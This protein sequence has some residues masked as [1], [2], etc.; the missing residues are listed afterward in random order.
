[1]DRFTPFS[2]KNKKLVIGSDR[3]TID[4][5]SQKP[6]P[7]IEQP[8]PVEDDEPTRLEYIKSVIPP[9]KPK[10]RWPLIIG[11][12]IVV[13]VLAAG[14]Y[15]GFKHVHRK[16][17]TVAHD[18]TTRTHL[19]KPGSVT[20]ATSQYVSNGSDLNLTFTYPSNWSATPASG[21]NPNDQTITLTSPIQ[22]IVNSAG[23]AVSG[24]VVV[25]LRPASSTMS[26]LSSGE[27]T[28]ALA[29]TQFDYSKPTSSQ[30]QYPYLTYLD[31]N[32]GSNPDSAFQ[33]V[34][35]TGNTS[36]TQG[37]NITESSISVDP[38]IT[39]S[40]DACTTKTCTGNG[41]PLSITYATWQ[42]DRVFQQTAALFES[43]SLN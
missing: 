22:T 33:E 38:I 9:G 36:F 17:V 25:M 41:S 4:S 29:S 26:E 11:L 28:A 35:I 21:N 7:V 37:Q 2:P 19:L 20:S 14:G 40:I 30:Y 5:V 27:A 13:L 3:P 42:N 12:V 8:V 39:A 18:S 15:I 32:P 23:Q 24:K 16:H 31:L 1:M 10:R 6:A 34:V 43:L